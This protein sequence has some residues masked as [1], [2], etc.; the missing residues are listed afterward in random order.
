AFDLVTQAYLD[1]YEFVEGP[2]GEVDS[3]LVL[4]I[5]IDM[6]ENLRD[7]IKS[8]ESSDKV[9]AQIDMILSDLAQA[10]KVVPEFGTVTM[11]ILAVAIVS[12]IG[13]TAR[14]KISLRA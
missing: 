4:K 7:M 11:M 12:I 10:K 6:R 14:S 13:F 9:D 5:E 1:N 3:E 8:N 2:L